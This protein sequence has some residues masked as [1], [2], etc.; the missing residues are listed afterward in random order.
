MQIDNS[1]IILNKTANPACITDTMFLM[2]KKWLDQS[3]QDVIK[4]YDCTFEKGLN[5]NIL[6]VSKNANI[7]DN[8]YL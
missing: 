4:Y 5:K 7:G 1:Q 8:Y 2:G 3:F 6:L